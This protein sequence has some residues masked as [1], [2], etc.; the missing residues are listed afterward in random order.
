MDHCEFIFD[1][2]LHSAAM[3]SLE[4]GAGEALFRRRITTLI[5]TTYN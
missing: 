1:I 4:S 3:Y 2:K 5:N